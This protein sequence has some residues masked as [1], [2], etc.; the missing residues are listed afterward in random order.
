[1]ND[2]DGNLV[3]LTDIVPK[4]KYLLIDFWA[5]WCG[6]CIHAMPKVVTLQKDYE[7]WL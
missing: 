7:E 4:G 2:V 5:S 1:M 3:N 6:M